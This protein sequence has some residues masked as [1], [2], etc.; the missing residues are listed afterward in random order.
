MTQTSDLQYKSL[1]RLALRQRGGLYNEREMLIV[2]MF[3]SS[4]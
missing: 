1:T 2:K 4:F 3:F